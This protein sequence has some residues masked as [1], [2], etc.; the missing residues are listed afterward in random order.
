MKT[1]NCETI[2]NQCVEVNTPVILDTSIDIENIYVR[3]SKPQIISNS[4]KQCK[5]KFIIKQ[6]ISVDIPIKYQIEASISNDSISRAE[7]DK[8]PCSKELNK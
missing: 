7:E 3:C 5:S 2:T 8:N 4:K 6:T 1:N